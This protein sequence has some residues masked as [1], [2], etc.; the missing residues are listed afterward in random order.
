LRF[1]AACTGGVQQ[2]A[3]NPW[4]LGRP[5]NELSSGAEGPAPPAREGRLD[6]W[7]KIAAYLK[8]D[9]STVQRWERRE[10]MPVHRHQHDKQGSV[11]AY[12]SELD[13]WWGSRPMPAAAA[14]EGALEAAPPPQ[15]R[16]APGR[17]AGLIGLAVLA[18]AALAWLAWRQLTVWHDPLA[19]ARYSRIPAF[20]ETNQ[21]AAISPDGRLVAFIGSRDGRLDAWV[22]ELG[23]GV[24][25]NLTRG[26]IGGLF[27]P[28]VRAIDFSPDSALVSIWSRKADGTQP[29]DVSRYAVPVAGGELTAYL[30][31]AAEVAWAPDGKRFVY[32]T[33]APGD[34]LFVRDS[35]QSQPHRIYLA[36]AG[37]HCHFPVWSPDGQYIYFARGVPPDDW[38]IW[39]IRPTGDA[40][41]RITNHGARLIYP[42]MLDG[43]TLLYLLTESDGSGPWIYGLDVERRIPHRISSGLDA[44]TSLSASRTGT[45]LVATVSNP[46]TSLWRID[47]GALAQHGPTGAP[48]FVL[49]DA[50]TPRIGPGFLVFVSSRGGVQGLWTLE[51]GTERRIWSDP[52]GR[53]L[54][55]PA[56]AADGHLAVSVQVGAH[57]HLLV[58]DKDGA[59][60]RSLADSLELR[61]DPAWAPDSQSVIIAAV[62]RGEP[63]LMKISL[64]AEAPAPFVSEYSV[65]PVWS[66]GGDFLIY[67]GP[68][69]GTTFPLRAAAADGRPYAIPSLILTRGARHVG[70]L[71][72][73]LVVTRGEIGHKNLWLVDLKSGAQRELAELPADFVIGEFDVASDGSQIVLERVED[74]A[75]LALIE[76]EG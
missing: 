68:D 76:R 23:S 41:E 16:P 54:G 64:G 42:V 59:H 10:G 6:S 31:P 15:A 75:Y 45:R 60:V 24:Y 35:A 40:L 67:S 5:L 72:G 1:F 57:T 26:R 32:H 38:D 70:L 27:N 65:D 34:P 19:N 69:V 51:R 48:S 50:G 73:A 53:I 18:A 46:R 4:F 22:G 37:V 74:S 43:R 30:P 47:L 66:A 62:Q 58:M 63:R 17:S 12:R 36:T 28:Q 49:A 56:I 3:D 39:R 25:R 9:V 55:A 13:A 52:H 20:S 61:G 44:Y 2:F 14:E 8:R 71:G 7:K 21:A 11:F 29:S 33:T